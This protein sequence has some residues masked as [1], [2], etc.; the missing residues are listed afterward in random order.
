MSAYGYTRVSTTE[1]TEGS[2]LPEQE[3]KIRAV[4]DF[5]DHQLTQIFQEP[6][7]SGNTPFIKRPAGRKLF[8][9]LQPGD[10]VI[11]AKLDR[12]FRN[13][14]DAL[15]TARQ[16]QEKQ[17]DLVIADIGMDPVT[18]N[19]VGKLFFTM[20]AALAEF[21]R[22]RITERMSEGRAAKKKK[23]GYLGGIVP[24]GYIVS[25]A[26]RE[27]KLLP[28][29]EKQAAI[30]LIKSLFAQGYP[31]RKISAYLKAE[32]GMDLSH[33]AV[34]RIAKRE[35]RTDQWPAHLSKEQ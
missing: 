14:E 6:G 31:L 25:G 7:V 15:T 10:T 34:G 32:T 18:G 29:R 2:S 3:R 35:L 1:Q 12:A 8:A 33:V 9:A 23:A 19:G 11:V 4:A 20:L 5:H 28:D 22:E 17:V 13:A 16:L 21:E 26:G 24:F 27:A 30:K